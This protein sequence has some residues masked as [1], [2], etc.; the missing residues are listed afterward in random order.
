MSILE[1]LED[2]MDGR[3]VAFE[4]QGCKKLIDVS[5]CFDG[6]FGITLNKS[7]FGEMI[8]E[9]TVLHCDMKDT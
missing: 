3:V 1:R 2:D 9:L 7:E 4:V 8:A 6:W 5:E